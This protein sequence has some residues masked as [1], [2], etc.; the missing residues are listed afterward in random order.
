MIPFVLGV[1]ALLALAAFFLL[2]P[3]LRTPRADAAGED[4]NTAN[5]A[6]LRDQ[7]TELDREF[8]EG[9]LSAADRTQAEQELQRRLLEELP[10]TT[11]AAAPVAHSSRHTAM[12][13]LFA[14]PL[15]AGIGYALLGTPQAL[16]PAQRAPQ[17]A[18]PTPDQIAAMVDRLAARLRD[19]PD[20]MEGWLRLARAYK[21]M[22]RLAESAEAYGKAEKAIQDNAPL[23]ADYAEVLAM[24]QNN[25]LR[26]KPAAL[27]ARALQVDP[28]NPHALLLA[29]AVAMENGNPDLAVKTWEK[30]LPMVEPGS[31]VEKVLKDSIERIRAQQNAGK[32]P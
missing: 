9:S 2:P 6:I 3:L 24:S 4:R 20:D 16:D 7:L 5:L 15:A 17:M 18:Q 10:V 30:L 32:K 23:L 25:G 22:G 29:G 31:E 8:A 12:A 19:N 26:G 1:V 13:L 21:V 14:V 11:P 27:I 28:N